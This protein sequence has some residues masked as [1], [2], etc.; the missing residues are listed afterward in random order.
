M[1]KGALF[2][3][4]MLFC[5]GDLLAQKDYVIL[6]H[7]GAGNIK[8]I[9]GDKEKA[10]QY[11]AAL[12]SALTIGG[13]I[14]STGA[15]GE[16]AVR[17]VINYFENNPLFNAGKGATCTSAGTFELDASIMEGKDLSA[18]AVAGVK[19]IKHPID[20]AWAVKTKTPHVMLAGDGAD[21]FAKVQ[22][23]DT[24]ADNLYFATPKTMKW[25]DEF[26]KASKKKY[27]SFSRRFYV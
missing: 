12:D 6:V 27:R 21:E 11:Y 3:F 25:V 23:L 18:G 26:K 9:E 10:A 16:L 7:G 5:V 20:A 19:F 24:V 17:A 1:K 22:G 2:I 4:L 8:S 15:D 14:L 13:G